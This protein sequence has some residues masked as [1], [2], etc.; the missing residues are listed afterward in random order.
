ML[1]ILKVGLKQKGEISKEQMAPKL[2]GTLDINEVLGR[3]GESL[4]LLFTHS[5]GL[6]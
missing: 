6:V 5:Q 2:Y 1:L 3:G 4:C